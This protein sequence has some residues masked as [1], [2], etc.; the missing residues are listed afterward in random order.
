MCNHMTFEG[1][2]K[3][4]FDWLWIGKNRVDM[5]DNSVSESQQKWYVRGNLSKAKSSTSLDSLRTS[6][7]QASSGTWHEEFHSCLW[8]NWIPSTPSIHSIH[9]ILHFDRSSARSFARKFSWLW[10]WLAKR[11]RNRTIFCPCGRSAEVIKM[12]THK[13]NRI[14]CRHFR[15]FPVF[16]VHICTTHPESQQITSVRTHESLSWR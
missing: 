8:S 14:Q 15:V 12:S 5:S 9:S 1:I 7:L 11:W 16:E 13:T 2:R 10:E 4:S 3:F 6:T